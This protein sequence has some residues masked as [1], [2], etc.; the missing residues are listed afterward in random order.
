MKSFKEFINES[1]NFSDYTNNELQAFIKNAD[2]KNNK[3]V[4]A[5]EKLLKSRTKYIKNLT[6]D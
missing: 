4:K 6:K 2:D 3:D 1:K 5:A